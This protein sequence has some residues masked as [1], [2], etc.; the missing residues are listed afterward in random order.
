MIN[1]G[2]YRLKPGDRVRVRPYSEDFWKNKS[3]WQFRDKNGLFESA[4]TECYGF[5]IRTAA[6]N[7]KGTDRQYM[8]CIDKNKAGLSWKPAYNA[9]SPKQ[10]VRLSENVLMLICDVCDSENCFTLDN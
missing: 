10:G 3:S 4:Y 6:V 8:V 7:K 9:G 1:K 2:N 5:I